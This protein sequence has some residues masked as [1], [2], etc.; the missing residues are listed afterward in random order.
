M[1]RLELRNGQLA[2]GSKDSTIKIWNMANGKCFKTLQG[3][4]SFVSQLQQLES[5]ELVS[6]SFDMTIKIWNVEEGTCI[7]TLVGHT[8][9]VDSITVN[10]RNNTL[11]S[12]SWDKTIK[13]WDWKTG[14]CVKTILVADEDEDV[15]APMVR[16]VFI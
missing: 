16:V 15:E 10:S 8:S 4:S 9:S 6:S 7:R 1:I 2:S 11:A 12:C 5:G 3:H 13:T 14:V